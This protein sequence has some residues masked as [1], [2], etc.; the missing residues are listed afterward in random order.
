M[1]DYYVVNG[2][3]WNKPTVDLISLNTHSVKSIEV[4]GDEIIF[5][6]SQFIPSYGSQSGYRDVIVRLGNLYSTEKAARE[7]VREWIAENIATL[8]GELEKTVT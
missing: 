8:Q 3:Y 1:S 6:V 7:R 5:H 4:D 2:G